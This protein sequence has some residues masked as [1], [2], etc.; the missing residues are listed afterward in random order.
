MIL[1]N[2][3]D[4]FE[5]KE[6]HL[7]PS[8]L[9]SRLFKYRGRDN[10][11]PEEN[12]LTEA[13][14]YLLDN[15][16][17]LLQEILHFARNKF[18]SPRLLEDFSLMETEV[19]TQKNYKNKS[20]ANNFIDL[21]VK[22]GLDLLWFEMKVESG[23]S[24]HDQIEK[25]EMLLEERNLDENQSGVILLTKHRTEPDD[26]KNYY[27]GNILWSEIYTEIREHLGS[28]DVPSPIRFI[29]KEFLIFL[30][31][32]SM[33]P[34]N[35]FTQ[36]EFDAAKVMDGVRKKVNHILNSLLEKLT[37]HFTGDQF[38]YVRQSYGRDYEG[39]KVKIKGYV[40]YYGVFMGGDGFG[41][42]DLW[43]L[44]NP[45]QVSG[46]NLN[47]SELKK[48][49]FEREGDNYLFRTLDSEARIIENKNFLEESSILIIDAID[50]LL[51]DK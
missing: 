11:S 51:K 46:L 8:N 36:E 48:I 34:F 28:I 14:A 43:F 15:D 17:A 1:E 29:E 30:E 13:F 37:I 39:Q 31:E 7:S 22:S 45:E 50:A 41:S 44:T 40:F 49:G 24:G 47:P 5:D 16:R 23:L 27:L 35:P 21:E 19:S 2:T 25:Y 42:I 18:D 33:A 20:R 12:F 4:Q 32:K 9:F 6:R 38:E 3:E 10:V 26:H